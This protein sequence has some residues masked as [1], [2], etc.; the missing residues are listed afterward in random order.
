MG[1]ATCPRCQ[2][3]LG[4]NAPH[5][6]CG[7]CLLE[8]AL[9]DGGD[10]FDSTDTYR[11]R[12]FGDYELLEEIAHGGMGVVYKARQIRLNRLVALKMILGGKLAGTADL[13][14]FRGEAEAVANLD[15]PNIVPIYEVGEEEGQQY[16]TMKLI[17]GG[18]LAQVL[19]L[20][21]SRFTEK[22][23]AH[24]VTILA[25]AVH[26]AHQH[27][28]LHRDL[29][30]ANILIDARGQPHITDFGLAKNIKANSEVTVSGTVI[31][32]PAYMAP[33]QAA[34]RTK[35][36]STAVDVYSLGAI[37]YELLTGRPPFQADTLLETLRMVTDEEPAPPSTV[38]RRSDR[39][40]ETICLKCLEKDP[41][42]RYGSAEALADDL[43][44][45]LHHEPIRARRVSL[46]ERLLKYARRRPALAALFTTIFLA[47]VAISVIS[48]TLG[49]RIA[50]SKQAVET[51]AQRAQRES[52]KNRQTAAF[53]SR[54][55]GE[56]WPSVAQGRDTALLK[57]IL[58]TTTERLREL[59]GQP[60]VELDLRLTLARAYQGLGLFKEQE[61]MS[62]EAARLAR[63][64]FGERHE[65]VAEALLLQAYALFSEWR[66]EESLAVYDEVL[67][68]RKNLF[69]DD[70]PSVAWVYSRMADVHVAYG[71]RDASEKLWQQALRIQEKNR[72]IVPMSYSLLSLGRIMLERGDISSA[73]ENFHQAIRVQEQATRRDDRLV[74]EI[75]MWL[76]T[77]LQARNDWA[78]SEKLLQEVL[79]MRIKAYGAV[80]HQTAHTLGMI[81]AA[82][83][84]Q[85]KFQ[86]AET[87]LME[88]LAIEKKAHGEDHRFVATVL[89]HLA[90]L[91]LTKGELTN[92]QET[93]RQAV[94]MEERALGPEHPT[95]VR[96][97]AEL[98]DLLKR[99]KPTAA[100][101]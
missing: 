83:T 62:R 57:E 12:M 43:E 73:E 63:A 44:R 20:G 8:A 91:Y 5:A 82:Q 37:L 58:K 71:N 53:L 28:I 21:N 68:I 3:V 36:V 13:Q 100:P 52:E 38:N 47:L 77:A 27:G 22:E 1:H 76:A 29:K 85:G 16:F 75:T 15:H 41:R 18:S 19:S 86:I 94:A 48:T 7:A 23:R 34:G 40:L 70:H 9:S 17:E 49:L 96:S 69:G 24:L 79:A 6:L 50:A 10:L 14:R 80:H 4:G 66:R 33:E 2:R 88:A 89:T 60:E 54:M 46:T 97:R 67:A 59:R 30:P 90:R 31:G 35:E 95:T 42:R 98:A 55:I 93:L 45:W 84:R 64:H 32:T 78:G 74:A 81:A 101:R 39:D 51:A 11:E 99:T 87:N 56:V 72:Q 92:A 26:C 65:R 61:I 25:R